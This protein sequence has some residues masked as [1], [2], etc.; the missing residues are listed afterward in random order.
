[1]QLSHACCFLI[2]NRRGPRPD[3]RLRLVQLVEA[4]ARRRGERSRGAIGETGSDLR[5]NR[6][7]R[8]LCRLRGGREGGQSAALPRSARLPRRARSAGRRRRLP[9]GCR[10]LAYRLAA[11]TF[12]CATVLVPQMIVTVSTALLFGML[13]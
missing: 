11:G 9:A 12:S 10:R 7:K 8:L 13:A 3:R 6:G 2:A 5:R 4:L 1:R